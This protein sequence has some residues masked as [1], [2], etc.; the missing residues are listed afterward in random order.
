LHAPGAD[1]TGTCGV[2]NARSETAVVRAVVRSILTGL[3][4]VGLAALAVVLAAAPAL[5][6]PKIVSFGCRID[7]RRT[8]VLPPAEERDSYDELLCRV[9]VAGLGGRSARD[10][11][12][13]LLLM[14]P[15]GSYRVVATSHL[16]PSERGRDRG[17]LDELA[18]PHATWAAGIDRS[19]P[20]RPR[21]RLMV[22]LLDRP[23]TGSRQWRLLAT[24]AWE[25]GGKSRPA[26]VAVSARTRS[27]RK[28]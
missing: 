14:P 12:V 15:D 19:D 9:T 17:Q 18:V 8:R 6:A 10:L 21:V 2:I 7:G 24:R 27:A 16:E 20:R 26:K 13:E 3:R 4:R 22:R 1:D 5:A 25:L 28:R 23:P 11:A